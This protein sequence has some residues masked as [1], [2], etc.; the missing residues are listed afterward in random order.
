[1][2]SRDGVAL[3]EILA[4]IVILAIAGLALVEMV[5]TAARAEVRAAQQERRLADAERLLAAHALLTRVDLDRR[6]GRRAIGPYLV[7]IQ[8]PEAG[9]Y[10]IAVSERDASQREELVTVVSLQ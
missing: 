5:S 6:L 3:L 2:R 10:R 4:A 7:E 8:R 9:L 1:M